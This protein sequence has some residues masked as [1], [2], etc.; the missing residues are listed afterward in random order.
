MLQCFNI[1]M[2]GLVNN[3]HRVQSYGL[4]Q[5]CVDVI[6]S[7][8]RGSTVIIKFLVNKGNIDIMVIFTYPDNGLRY[9]SIIK[10]IGVF[11]SAG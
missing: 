1:V 10:R 8:S 6:S 4:T 11:V 3:G 9:R 2:A 7:Y 5:C